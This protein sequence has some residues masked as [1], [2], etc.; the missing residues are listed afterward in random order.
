MQNANGPAPGLG[1]L[2]VASE[3]ALS[4]FFA[5]QELSC[6][7][8]QESELFSFLTLH[9]PIGEAILLPLLPPRICAGFRNFP[10]SWS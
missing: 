6:I 5:S 8:I 7:F 10:N 9:P 4:C 1:I 2:V 3:F